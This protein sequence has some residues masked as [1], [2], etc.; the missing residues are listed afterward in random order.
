MTREEPSR[1]LLDRIAGPIDAFHVMTEADAAKANQALEGMVDGDSVEAEILE[2]L[3]DSQPLAEPDAFPP[4][5][6]AFVRS[7]EVYNRNARRTPAGLSAGI[8]TPIVTPVVTLL[9]ATVANSFQD[10]VIRDVR[11]LYLMREAN[12]PMGSRE[13]RMLASARRQLDA[14]DANMARRG[15]AIP[16]FLVGGAVLSA[17]ASTLNELLRSNLGRLGLLIVILLVTIGA[18]WCLVRAAAITRRRTRLILDQ[19]MALLWE[20]IG[21]AGKPPH[22][23][24]RAFLA[25]A[26]VLLILG[27]VLAPLAVAVIFSLT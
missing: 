18:F 21:G 1:R 11:R 26:T 9:T 2:E 23:P 22:E 15:S 4:L 7:L 6:R 16:A 24:S 12:S 8:F 25:A 3:L 20:A 14:L 27:W 10:R 19:P 17:V 5:H 13:H